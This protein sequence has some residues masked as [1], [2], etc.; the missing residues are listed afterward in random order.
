MRFDLIGETYCGAAVNRSNKTHR[1]EKTT[2]PECLQ[3]KPASVIRNSR[4]II[5]KMC[6]NKITKCGHTHTTHYSH[7]WEWVNC[8]ECIKRK[9]GD[10]YDRK[11]GRAQD[12]EKDP[13]YKV[14]N[15]T[16]VKDKNGRD[17]DVVKLNCKLREWFE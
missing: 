16:S 1:W 14:S 2:C 6:G 8:P 13:S 11:F 7:T 12:V 9:P 3:S 15:I 17:I 10:I 5:H 4:N